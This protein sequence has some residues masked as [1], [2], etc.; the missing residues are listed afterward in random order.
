MTDGYLCVVTAIVHCKHKGGT[1]NVQLQ[2][3]PHAN[4]NI[5]DEQKRETEDECASRGL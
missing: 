2:E 3:R 4:T 1:M 5:S